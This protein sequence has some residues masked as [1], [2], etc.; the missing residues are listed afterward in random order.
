[1]FLFLVP[2][3]AFL[4]CARYK[5]SEEVNFK[6]CEIEDQAIEKLIHEN[7]EIMAN[8]YQET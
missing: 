8:I 4:R 3:T 6:Y 7:E 1:M 2:S 5:I